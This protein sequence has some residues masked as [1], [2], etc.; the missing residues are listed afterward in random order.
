MY[1]PQ[2][3][4][5][6]ML[7]FWDQNDIFE[8][9]RKKNEGN[10]KWTLIDGPIT[11]NENMCIHHAYS[12]TCKDL[13]QRWKGMQGYKQRYQNG[14]DTQGLPIEVQA[15]K[16]F[17]IDS[18]KEIEE[19]G[20]DEFIEKCKKII[21]KYSK[22]QTEDSIR[23][24]QWM[25]WENSYYTYKDDYI[26]HIWHFIKKCDEKDLLFEGSRVMWWCPRCGTSLSQQEIGEGYT[27]L[28]DNS[29]YITLP[30]KDEDAYLM[31]WTTTPWTLSANVVC[32]VNPEEVYAEVKQDGKTYYMAKDA[33]HTTMKG[34]YEIV[35]EFKGEKLI[36]K[37]YKPP[38]PNLPA[39]EEPEH[40]VVKWSEVGSTEG[41]GIVHIAPGCGE[42]DEELGKEKNLA[43]LSP[44]KGDGEYK[45]G[46]GWLTGKYVN[47]V[48]E[49]VIEDL[50]ERNVLY[51]TEEYTHQYPLCWRCD[52]K[53]IQR[54]AGGEW[55]IDQTQ[56]KEKLR[57]EAEKVQWEP[58]YLEKE[59]YNWLDNMEE[60]NISRKRYWGTP[61][62][63]WK[64]KECDNKT[65][66]GSKK[67]LEEK[68]IKGIEQLEELHKPWIDKVK[69]ECSECKGEME[70][71]EKTGDVWI[72]SGL[73]PYATLNY[74]DDPEYF[75][76]WFPSN[77]IAEGRDQ[78]TNWFH[79][80]MVVSTIL[81]KQT[82]YK[83]V[84]SFEMVIDDEGKPMS[85][86][87][88]NVIPAEEA[89]EKIGMDNVRWVFLNGNPSTKTAIGYESGEE[90]EQELSTLFNI[91]QYIQETAPKRPMEKLP[92]REN[93]T[94]ED[95]WLLSR[96]NTMKKKVNKQLEELEPHKAARE[97]KEFFLEDF[98][99]G[100]IQ[101]IRERINEN[102][103]EKKK[104]SAVMDKA[105]LDTLKTM[106]PFTPF[107]TERIYQESYREDEKPESIHLFS[108][109][110]PE[111]KW[112]DEELE[113]EMSLVEDVN[114]AI[115]AL[116]SKIG[117]GVRW[118]VKKAIIET[119]QNEMKE[120]AKEL[121]RIIREQ[122]N[123]R[124]VEIT[125][126]MPEVEKKVSLN[127][128]AVGAEFQQDAMKVME[129]ARDEL[130]RIKREIEEQGFA[131]LDIGTK[132]V[133]LKRK[134][135]SIDRKMPEN[136][137]V[138]EFNKGEIYLDTDTT[139]ELESE[140]YAREVMRHTQQLRKD[141]G[142]D[143]EQ[144]I[145]LY[146]K[147]D[148]KLKEML[149]GHRKDIKNRT[150][151]EEIR[152]SSEEPSES[153]KSSKETEVKEKKIEI[154]FNVLN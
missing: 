25:D 36:G 14:F 47:E 65:V 74:L 99:R 10:E 131:R 67:E 35:D 42:E 84:R 46:Y 118:P 91:D 5:K 44:I 115:L 29:I 11:A 32:A 152:I 134:H 121:E 57:E 64:C 61:I 3:V 135:I 111:K 24:G 149:E 132:E 43:S 112:I 80:T 145:K 82:P 23:L 49:E 15:E 125:E 143:K 129:E 18:K 128:K 85:K 39:Q 16:E 144:D 133:K 4:E 13:Y 81:E 123:V 88:G 51:R 37:H 21:E 150:G 93:L 86:S 78:V 12:R 55:F 34:D 126:D 138:R 19:M 87:K 33:V 137:E 72:D 31:A 136:L 60:W 140:G 8:K 56:I 107:L 9:R 77:L 17:G 62:P 147:A 90:A 102:E 63:I 58:E 142:L 110:E 97:I 1:N 28:T 89:A 40:K 153:Y 96:L 119:K 79:S 101:Y 68:A 38:H 130:K 100:Y 116:R 59:Y 41:T 48:N 106:A 108:W 122:T 94:E 103:E 52:E 66:I 73:V 98:S 92:G 7:E 69:L 71:V 114:E 53:L 151:S 124:E 120:A 127:E 76:N 22:S 45:E 27:Q 6:E 148:S 70:R 2:E 83:K 20:V 141:E 117:R 113:T 26:E 139:P 104:V 154:Y 109:P 146:I 50:K 54:R 30:L 95:R 75:W 105:L